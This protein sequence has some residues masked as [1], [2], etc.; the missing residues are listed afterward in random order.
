MIKSIGLDLAL[1]IGVD[2]NLPAL[3]KDNASRP[4]SPKATLVNPKIIIG[5]DLIRK[6]GTGRHVPV[7][8]AVRRAI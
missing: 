2:S 7:I 3:Q 5:R 1:I 8:T 4:Y 6:R